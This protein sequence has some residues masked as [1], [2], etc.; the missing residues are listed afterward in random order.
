MWQTKGA[1]LYTTPPHIVKRV[2]TMLGR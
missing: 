2:R 1:N